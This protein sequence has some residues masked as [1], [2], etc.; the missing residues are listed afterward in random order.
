MS[1]SEWAG[2]LGLGAILLI[3]VALGFLLGV[4]LS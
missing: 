2:L 4:V 1:G 3:G